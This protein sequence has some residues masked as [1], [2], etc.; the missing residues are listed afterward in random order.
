MRRPCAAGRGAAG[1]EDEAGLA[2]EHR[3]RHAREVAR[4][5]RGVAVHEADDLGARGGQAREAGRAE[6]GHRLADDLGAE[7][8]GQLARAVGRP[9]VD[10]DRCVAVG[11][12]LEHPR[13]CRALV[14]DGEDDVR[15]GLRRYR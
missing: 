8:C 11:H 10:H 7:L 1:A 12:P 9:V 14:E 5:E 3:R 4:V 2:G 15:H 6:P 13:Q